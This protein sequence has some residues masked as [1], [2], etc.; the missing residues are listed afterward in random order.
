MKAVGNRGWRRVPR[1][2][3]ALGFVSLL[4]DVSSEMIHA[5][6]PLLLVD[7]LGVGVAALGVIE[8]IAKATASVTKV[9]SGAISDRLGRRKPLLVLGYALGA[10]SKP[11]FPLAGSG[12]VILAARVADRFGKGVR[13]APRDALVADITPPEIRGAAYGLRQA[14]DSIGAFAGPLLAVLLMLAYDGRI[15]GVLWWAVLPAVASVAVAALA[16]HEPT[17]LVRT[18]HRGWPVR[19]RELSGLGGAF[20]VVVAIGVLFTLARFSEAFLILAG[21][22]AGLPLALVPLVMVC[23]NAA[24]AT[25]A[26]PAGALSD[27]LGRRGILIAG[28]LVLAG[29]DLVLAAGFGIAGLFAGAALW[30]LHMAL[31][32]GLLAALVADCAPGALRAT[33]FGVFNLATGLALLLASVVAGVLWQALGPAATLAAGGAF[34]VAAAGTMALIPPQRLRAI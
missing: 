15:R 34:A 14:L 27:R 4:M 8:G 11:I 19:G 10:V 25:G 1:S 29:A 32:Q 23:M 18:E 7:S 24:Y 6:L 5:L 31:S 9:F 2:V 12:A 33:A 30:G 16:V 13:G 20:W 28:M 3:W 21:Q 26:M 22:A 17:G